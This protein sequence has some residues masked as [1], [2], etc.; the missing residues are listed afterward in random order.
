MILPK[1]KPLKNQE[2]GNG[3]KKLEVV[4]RSNLGHE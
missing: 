4:S 1:K 3:F 2:V